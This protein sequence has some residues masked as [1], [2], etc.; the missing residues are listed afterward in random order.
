[1]QPRADPGR[2]ADRGEGLDHGVRADLH[3]DVDDR[4]R[5][6]DDR[7]RRRACGARG[8]RAGRCA[9]TRASAAR[10]LTPSTR[11]SSS[12]RCAAT[13]APSARSRSSTCGRYSSPCALSVPSRGS[14]R[15]S[16]PR[17]E[18]EDARVD[19]ADLALGLRSSRPSRLGL[20]HARRRAVGVAHDAPVAARVL[21]HRRRH[22]RRRAAARVRLEQLGDRL[23]R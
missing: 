6:V 21:E 23:R 12:S 2:A 11:R 18:H 1:M 8:S 15:R 5:R 13:R 3:V 20:D 22:R 4:R 19:L 17:G 9:R 7:P 14:A 10:S 16:A